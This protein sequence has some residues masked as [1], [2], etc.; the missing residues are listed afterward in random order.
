MNRKEKELSMMELCHTF[1]DRNRCIFGGL[2]DRVTEFQ[3]PH[4]VIRATVLKE[5]EHSDSVIK[6]GHLRST[7]E[8]QRSQPLMK[9]AECQERGNCLHQ[10]TGKHTSAE[11]ND[12]SKEWNVRNT[13][14][15]TRQLVSH[16]QTRPAHGSNGMTKVSTNSSEQ[17]NARKG[18]Q[19][20]A[21]WA[22]DQDQQRRIQQVRGVTKDNKNVT[23]HAK[24]NKNQLSAT[25]PAAQ[26]RTTQKAVRSAKLDHTGNVTK[27]KL[28]SRHSVKQPR[29]SALRDTYRGQQRK[30]KEA[31][32]FPGSCV[33]V[34]K[35][36][37]SELHISHD[38]HQVDSHQAR[39][40]PKPPLMPMTTP[41]RDQEKATSRQR[42]RRRAKITPPSRPAPEATDDGRL[43]ISCAATGT[44]TGRKRPVV[45]NHES[46]G[47]MTQQEAL[48][49]SQTSSS[50]NTVY[51]HRCSTRATQITT[52]TTTR[53]NQVRPGR[54]IALQNESGYNDCYARRDGLCHHTDASE[55]HELTFIRVLRKRF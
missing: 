43:A 30:A 4:D 52:A 28:G 45:Q 50:H 6:T 25:K 18:S 40:I 29:T 36:R 32:E 12:R 44:V 53:E 19:M 54:R 21:A 33:E 55:Q 39:M 22:S 37:I 34:A 47:K 31:G 20:S 9:P 1:R 24:A 3:D 27:R 35:C 16:D 8:Q 46:Q 15:S 11:A 42:Y 14:C 7:D 41:H 23:E 2:G 5:S 38:E 17:R 13:F 48:K 10:G 49:K 51:M 26:R